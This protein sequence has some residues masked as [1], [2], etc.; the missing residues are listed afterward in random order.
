MIQSQYPPVLTI[1]G[2]DSSGGAGVQADLKTMTSLGCYGMSAITAITAQNTIGV[3]AVYPIPSDIVLAQL[4]SVFDDIPPEAVKIGML[5]DRELIVA[6]YGFLKNRKVKIILDPVMV[7]TSGDVL[8]S[9]ESLL[10]LQD[11][12][13]PLASLITP[14]IHEMNLIC[15]SPVSTRGHMAESAREMAMKWSTPFLVKGGDL[16]GSGTSSDVLAVP[17]SDALQWFESQRIDTVHTHGTGCTLSSA[18]A[19]YLALGSSLEEAISLS[20]LYINAALEF[21]KQLTWGQ[22]PWFCQSYVEYSECKERR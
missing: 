22:G 18:I 5:H 7:A 6:L 17:G 3:Q 20:K 16:Q 12:L 14:N 4:E 1:A 19:S 15:G 2:S 9:P 13:F 10:V 21:G 8:S 11:L